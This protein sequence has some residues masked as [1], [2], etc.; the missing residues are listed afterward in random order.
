[1]V[2]WA[3]SY[4]EAT[5]IVKALDQVLPQTLGGLKDPTPVF[6]ILNTSAEGTELVALLVWEKTIRPFGVR[7][8]G[9]ELDGKRIYLMG[10]GAPDFFEFLQMHPEAVPESDSADGL[11]ARSTLLRFAGRALTRQ[12]ILG[13]GLENSWGGGFEI[14]YPD[15][16]G[17]RKL[18][19]VLF[20]AW[21]IDETGAYRN[22][23]RSFFVKYY[24]SDLHLS[25]FST[26]ERTFVIPSSV[27]I[28]TPPPEYEVLRPEWTMDVFLMKE[29][30]S[31]VE[32]ARYQPAH[33]PTIDAFEFSHGHLIGWAMDKEYVDARA[34][35]AVAQAPKGANFGLVRY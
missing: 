29:N 16:S 23:G 27:G 2:A 12:F 17:F 32:F 26:D 8:R 15:S 10:S 25:W 7:T 20:R 4:E 13:A 3:G 19:H 14:V 35:Q 33:R 11:V 6:D 24:G 34:E 5:R 21:M 18:D 28:S 31:F 9:F 22:S 1:M 30:G